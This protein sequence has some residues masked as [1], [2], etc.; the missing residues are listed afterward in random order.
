[1]SRFEAGIN[2]IS[3]VAFIVTLLG[4]TAAN[5]YEGGH[6]YVF[7]HAEPGNVDYDDMRGIMPSKEIIIPEYK[8]HGNCS[9]VTPAAYFRLR[10]QRR[11][12]R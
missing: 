9:S 11:P 3:A 6:P 8:T 7:R 2:G 10:A 12:T 4:A 1:M 5:T